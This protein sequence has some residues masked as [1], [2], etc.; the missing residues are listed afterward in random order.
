MDSRK[1]KKFLMFWPWL[2]LVLVFLLRLPSLFEPFTYADEGIYL[3]L[4]QAI[5]RGLVLYRDIYDNKPPLIY[6]LGAFT[7][8]FFNY[9]LIF[10]VWSLGTIFVFYQLTKL[11]FP[12]KRGVILLVTSIFA[13]LI[14]LPLFEGN[15]ANAENFMMLPIIG[16]FYLIIKIL[17]QTKITKG[18][19]LSWFSAGILF[20]LAILF[21]VPA[22]FD[23]LA[24]VL[25]CLFF[26]SK[27]TFKLILSR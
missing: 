16:S 25:L 5:R 23:F 20:S 15:I 21:K 13:I 17:E 19:F 26:L 22:L 11:L 9:R 27:K 8:N 2:L 4:G 6:L 12:K 3:T 7:G 24:V 1:L 18:N 14:S 10:L